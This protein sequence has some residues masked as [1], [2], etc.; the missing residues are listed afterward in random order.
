MVYNLFSYRQW[1]KWP[2]RTLRGALGRGSP[3]T[4]SSAS[5]TQ[6][7]AYDADSTGAAA[8]ETVFVSATE[9]R[10]M[11]RGFS[12]HRLWLENFDAIT[13][14]G[15]TLVPRKLLLATLGRMAGLDIY[16]AATK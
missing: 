16:V 12:Q 15:R 13:F 7:K 14:R 4:H 11:L 3:A 1:V 2:K 8:P 6:R 9:L 10:D 5:E